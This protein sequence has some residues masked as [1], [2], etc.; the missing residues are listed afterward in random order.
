MIAYACVSNYIDRQSIVRMNLTTTSSV[1]N[2]SVIDLYGFF[3]KKRRESDKILKIFFLILFFFR[4][5]KFDT[6]NETYAQRSDYCMKFPKLQI[7]PHPKNTYRIC[8]FSKF[9]FHIENDQ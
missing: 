7:T 9:S 2:V 6:G 8:Y 5:T 4:P 3:L 1:G